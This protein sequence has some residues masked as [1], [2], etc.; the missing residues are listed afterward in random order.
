MQQRS[1][2]R[3]LTTHAGSLPRPDDLRALL[4]AAQSG[5]RPDPGAFARACAA[6]VTY[7]VAKQRECG[8]DI[9]CDGEMSK[10]FYVGYVRDRFDGIEEGALPAHADINPV[11]PTSVEFPDIAAHPDF[12]AHRAKSGA[13]IVAAPV[14]AGAVAYRDLGPLESDI[15]W[16]KSGAAGTGTLFMNAASPGVLATFI[17]TAHYAHEDDYVTALATA[18][19]TEYEAIHRAGLLLQIDCPDLAM[20][21]HMRHW[22]AG[23]AAFLRIA[24]RNMEALN[25]ATAGIPAEAM[26]IH[27]CWGNYGGPHTHDFPVA[28]LFD[29]LHRTRAQ[30]IMFEG[31]NPRHEHEWEDWRQAGLPDDKVLVPG[32]ID[33]TTNFV[34]HPRL[35]AQRIKRYADIVGRER[36]I[37]GTD[38]GFGTFALRQ[39]QVFPS[40]VWSKL[41]ALAEGARMASAEL[42]RRRS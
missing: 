4:T 26:R 13:S 19:R 20:S 15:A 40:V 14:H 1:A 25:H 7:A 30:A 38:C 27:I 33:S 31:A 16:L 17:P 10:I 12:A 34:E 18:M 23:E 36:V 37:A 32:V 24:H 29:V 21:W 2:D 42:W 39:H 5:Q 8:I 9:I 28:R 11:L 41:A 3:I 22:R 35:V 6:A